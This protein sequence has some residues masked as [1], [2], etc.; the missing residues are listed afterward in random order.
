MSANPFRTPRKPPKPPVVCHSKPVI[1]QLPLWWFILITS[2][3]QWPPQPSPRPITA[4]TTVNHPNYP[5]LTPVTIIAEC[6]TPP[7]LVT[8]PNGIPT[9][10]GWL[11]DMDKPIMQLDAFVGAIYIGT[12]YLKAPGFAS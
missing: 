2:I 1:I 6:H 10:I 7:I 12:Q 4:D 8:V 9:A 5:P 11:Q 3:G